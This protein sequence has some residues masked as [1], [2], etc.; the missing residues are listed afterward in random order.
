MPD[1]ES[2]DAFYG[3]TVWSITSQMHELTGDDGLV[4]HAIREAYAKAYQQWYQVSGYSD[5]EGWVLATAKDAHE[6]RRAE[7]GADLGH[8]AAQ[9]GDSET[10]PGIYRPRQGAGSRAAAGPDHAPLD[11]EATLARPSAGA[12][13]AAYPITG[14]MA[15]S[16]GPQAPGRRAQRPAGNGPGQLG[17]RRTQVIAASAIA[18]LLVAG[19]A[20]LASSG[21][22]NAPAGGANSVS[23]GTNQAAQ[24]LP[25]GKTG[26]RSAVPWPLVRAGWALAEFSTAQP[27]SSGQPSGAGSYTTYLVDPKGGKYTITSSSGTA[28]QLMAWSGDAHEALFSTGSSPAGGASSY[29]LLNVQTGQMTP[30]PLPAGVV[31]VGFT[32]PDGLNILAVKIGRAKF[33][34][35]RYTLTGQLQASLAFLPRK[36]GEAW[37]ADGCTYACALSSP[38]GVFDVWGIVGDEM[39]SLGN[40]H[41]KFTRLP[42]TGRGQPSS[43]VPLS[44][45]DDTTILAECAATSLPADATGLW[46]VP[47]D[48]SNPT[49]LT[50]PAAAGSGHIYDAWLAGQ[51]TYVTSA[52]SRQCPSA[53]SGPSGLDIARLSQGS[54]AAITI[55]G[56]TGNVSTIVTTQGGR[57]LVLTQ[58]SCPGTSSLLW[59]NPSTGSS[60]VAVT[61]PSNEVGVIAAVPFGNGPTAVTSGQY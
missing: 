44:W 59:L 10:W 49:A 56:S 21:H 4:D 51:T 8:A 55:P 61:A 19:I 22:T 43:C 6:R 20:Y 28:P 3:R 18:A 53:T 33:H 15:G 35:Q 32:R 24:M 36:G 39:Q 52:T 40:A 13:A 11:P 60:Q 26:Q 38:E 29:Q 14:A 37:P 12:R 48:G 1:S 34:L 9:P 5:P 30:L 58:T 54:T 17:S 2:F 41:G 23:A 27:S 57:L 7:A 42:V 25:A 50:T 45:W 31:A 47:A 46:L 16:A